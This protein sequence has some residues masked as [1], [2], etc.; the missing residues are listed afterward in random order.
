M[1]VIHDG[2]SQNSV[3]T[4]LFS[5]S[6]FLKKDIN[7]YKLYKSLA[8]NFHYND[9]ASVDDLKNN[10][11]IKHIYLFV[12]YDLLN[13]ART[14]QSLSTMT[15]NRIDRHAIAIKKFDN[16]KYQDKDSINCNGSLL[17]LKTGLSNNKPVLNK[18]IYLSPQGKYLK[19]DKINDDGINTLINYS[20]D[21][22]LKQNNF[23]LPNSYLE[24]SIFKLY[25][26]FYDKKLYKKVYDDF[27]NSRVYELA[28]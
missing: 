28:I 21:G 16:C 5:D 2:G 8:N 15:E 26:G 12:N 13:L 24:T 20:K 17:N 14:I 1:S 27:P 6:M 9:E 7:A 3:A 10:L 4:H 19:T 18:I 25:F 23:M 22:S 11:K